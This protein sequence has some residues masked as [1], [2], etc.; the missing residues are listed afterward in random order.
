MRKLQ[1]HQGNSSSSKN[2]SEN[3]VP[4]NYDT[5]DKAAKQIMITLAIMKEMDF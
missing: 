5:A 4:H 3:T 1:E 2:V